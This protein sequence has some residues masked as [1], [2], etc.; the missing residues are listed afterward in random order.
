VGVEEEGQ[1]GGED[2]DVEP[3]R[4]PQLHVSEAVGQCV[5]QLLRGRRSGLA[6]VVAGDGQRLVVGDAGGAV[7]HEVADEAQMGLGLEQPLLLR[8]VLLEDVGLEGAVEDGRVDAL[9]F[10]GDEV[11]AEDRYGRPADGH[12]GRHVAE[13]DV[14]EE[15]LHVGGRVDG[16]P[17][18]PDLAEGAGVVGV[19]AHE[20]RHVEGDGEAPAAVGEDHLVA[21]V[22]LLGV[23]EPGELPDGPGTPPVAGRVQPPGVGVLPRPAD[24]LEALV[25]VTGPWPVHRLHGVTRERGEV[26]VALTR[27]VVTG[28]PASAAFLDGVSVHTLEF[29]R[30]S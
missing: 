26:C 17:A 6:D 16:D 1:A 25:R 20:G 5:R 3:A 2:V 21:L 29:T 27:G 28:L 12:R 19:T 30:T 4:K 22:G 13:G 15:D 18:V 9:P 10:G 23:P 8:D 7:L 11:H 14:L 24:A